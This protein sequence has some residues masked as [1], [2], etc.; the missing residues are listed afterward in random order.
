MLRLYKFSGDGIPTHYHEAWLDTGRNE[1]VEHFGTLG[2]AGA[3]RTHVV[4]GDMSEAD[5]IRRILA[6]PIADGFHQVRVEEQA[7]LV[8]EYAVN[9]MGTRADL[10]KRHRL[11]DKLNE[12]LGWTGLGHCDGGSI[13]AG[14]MEAACPV[15]H[16]E[17]A[18]RV[19]S[20]ALAG[21][22]FADF[23]RIYREEDDED[24]TDE[25]QATERDSAG[26]AMS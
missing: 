2:T 16:F 15:V 14:T 22:E 5:N 24:R 17:T 25:A 9:G 11:E 8:V 18:N 21:S 6:R 3:T 20:D 7:W 1:I 10:E 13:G 23:T 26:R 4:N 19:V 12:L